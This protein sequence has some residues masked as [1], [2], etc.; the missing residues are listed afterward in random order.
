MTTE[1][2]HIR[3]MLINLATAKDKRNYFFKTGVGDYAEHDQFI[4]VSVPVLRKITKQFSDLSSDNIQQLLTSSFNEERL[5]AL[6]ILVQQY[7]KSN[8]NNK[9]ELYQLYINNIKYVNNWNLVDASAHLILGAHII[10]KDKDILIT[11]ARS[12]NLWKRRIAIVATW[13]FTRLNECE[14]TF[15]IALLLLTDTHDLIH[16]SVGWMLRE[17]GKKSTPLLIDFL[18]IYAKQ[19]P[20]TMLRYAIEKLPEQQRKLYM[21]RN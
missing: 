17:A 20:R 19:M 15:K 18:D 10:H 1:I 4:N 7:Q 21:I 13:Y 6:F 9:N 8:D 12:N 5:L 3:S 11:L 2:S 14:W 16:K